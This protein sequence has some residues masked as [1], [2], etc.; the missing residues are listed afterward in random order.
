MLQLFMHALGRSAG[1][2]VHV[3]PQVLRRS[4]LTWGFQVR[5]EIEG[6]LQ[7]KPLRKVCTQFRHSLLERTLQLL[8]F[9]RL[10]RV[11][12]QNHR[13]LAIEKGKTVRRVRSQLDS[14]YISQADV[15]AF[16]L[17]AEND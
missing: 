6:D 3:E 2:Q 1:G 14:S 8:C 4:W 10:D 17:G 9:R 16:A 12:A 15:V 13:G 11:D 5:R 7:L